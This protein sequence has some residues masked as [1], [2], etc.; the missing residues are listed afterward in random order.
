MTYF[1]T[2]LNRNK[3]NNAGE[4]YGGAGTFTPE[5]FKIDGVPYQLNQ[6][7]TEGTSWFVFGEITQ[8][9]IIV[10]N[11][12]YVSGK[13][14]TGTF[15]AFPLGLI[16]NGLTFYYAPINPY[17]TVAERLK[18]NKYVL[19]DG[20]VVSIEYMDEPQQGSGD[21]MTRN[22]IIAIAIAFILALII[23]KI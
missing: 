9:P 17:L 11:P 7:S 22:I 10:T 16:D 4:L 12:V 21:N 2:Q 5:V 3:R 1:Q 13:V 18:Q 8:M 20:G 6:V 19:V 15:Y 23:N 14:A